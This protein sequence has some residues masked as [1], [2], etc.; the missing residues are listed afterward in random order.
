MRSAFIRT[1]VELAEVDKR[2]FLLVGD[3]GYSVV[4]LFRER[5]PGRFV[6]I[7]VAEQNLMGVAAGLALSGKIVFVYS[8]ANF[9]TL[10]CLEQIRNDLCYHN[11]NVKIVAIGG[12]VTYGTHGITHYATEDLAIM[13]AMPNMAV[14]APGDPLETE[15]AVKAVKDH[16]GPCYLRIGKSGEPNVHKG[17]FDFQIGKGILVCDGVQAVLIVIGNMLYN[18]LQA[19]DELKKEGIAVR[20][21]SMHTLKPIDKEIIV[22]ASKETPVIITIEEHGSV[23]GLGSAVAEILCEEGN[24]NVIFERI[25][26]KESFW[27]TIGSQGYIRRISGLSVEA[28]IQR[29]KD[30]I[31]RVKNRQ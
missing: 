30:A 21:I 16:T 5:F 2:V 29:I 18:A 27:N 8:L 12:G 14:L 9:P 23:G 13:R 20:L 22:K 24:K 19:V 11:A 6:N 28:I 25:D 7:G 10:R 3:L 26:L 31:L 4:E 1:L 17:L 15:M